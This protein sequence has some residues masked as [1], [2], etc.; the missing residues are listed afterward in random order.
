ML[1][2]LQSLGEFQRQQMQCIR[3]LIVHY[4]GLNPVD[5]KIHDL[6]GIRVKYPAVLGNDVAG[7]VE[8]TGAGV[9][10]FAKGIECM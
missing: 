9:T 10:D 4:L 6:D 7:I 1:V 5:W 3:R 2:K 8:K